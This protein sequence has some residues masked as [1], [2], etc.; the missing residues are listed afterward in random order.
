[1]WP[2]ERVLLFFCT[3]IIGAIKER[4]V[5]GQV[6]RKENGLEVSKKRL[7]TNEQVLRSDQ[8]NR[9]GHWTAFPLKMKTQP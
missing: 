3:A 6:D 7:P 4:D 2:L 8:T 1:M 5:G 9:E